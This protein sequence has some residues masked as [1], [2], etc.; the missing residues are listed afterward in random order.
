MLSVASRSGIAL[1]MLVIPTSGL[2]K[3]YNTSSSGASLNKRSRFRDVK[4]LVASATA[5]YIY[6]ERDSKLQIKA[7]LWITKWHFK[8]A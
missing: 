8:H 1:P 7:L 2:R 3:S 5:R 4:I 6:S